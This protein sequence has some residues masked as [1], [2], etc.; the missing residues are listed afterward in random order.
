MIEILLDELPQMF[1]CSRNDGSGGATVFGP[2]IEACVQTLTTC[3]RPAK[4][5]V[6]LATLP[7]G[8]APGQLKLRN[9][10]N[11]IGTRDEKVG[12]SLLLL[13]VVA[14]CLC[15]NCDVMMNG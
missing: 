6:F 5:I 14:F 2:V 1:S 15:L 8:V 13:V 12:Y 9:D 4:V 10:R 7:Q 11:L 3:E